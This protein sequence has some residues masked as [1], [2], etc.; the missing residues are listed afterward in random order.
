MINL[1]Q[2]S[3]QDQSVSYLG[4]IFGLVGS[5]LPTQNPNLLVGIL[6]KTLNTTALT[7]GAFLVVYVTVVGLLK[8]AQEGTFL[9]QHWN[10]LWVPIRTVIGI[11]ALFPTSSGYSAIQIVIMWIV[12]QG[13]GAADVIWTKVLDF[14]KVTGSVYTGVS[15]GS[16]PVTTAIQPQM[17]TLFQDLMC[18]ASA[19]A[20]YSNI[21][22]EQSGGSNPIKYYCGQPGQTDEFCTRS[23]SEMLNP[24]QGAQVSGNIYSMGPTS[25][26]CGALT[27]CDV[28]TSC[29]PPDI[30]DAQG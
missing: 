7:I 17:Q 5:L 1:F 28:K 14:V 11:A 27:L 20:K 26:K 29:T 8:T 13:V 24:L 3:Q 23:D 9:G 10:S 6:F 4:Q 15:S 2:I 16:L 21:S 30:K 22:T 25:G 18:Q 19:K 12:L